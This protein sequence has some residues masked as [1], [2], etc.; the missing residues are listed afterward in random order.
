[1]AL[2]EKHRTRLY[3]H[4]LDHI[5]E[6]TAE[7]VLAQFPSRDLDEPVTKEFVALTSAELGKEL[8]GLR[9][10]VHQ[11][12]GLLR[13]E[14]HQEVGLLRT[15]LHQ[16]TERLLNRVQLMAGLVVLALTLVGILLR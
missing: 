13:T 4:L 9:T 5:D 12:I 3:A 11:E 16:Q 15:E 14:L 1:M 10:E 6:E 2:Q 7:A 8:A